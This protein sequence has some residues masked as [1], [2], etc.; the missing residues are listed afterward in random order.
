M[1]RLA[2]IKIEDTKA[3]Y[4]LCARIA[5]PIGEYPLN[6]KRCR[7]QIIEFIRLF[8]K[9]YCCRVLGFCIMGN[10]YHLVVQM[11][12]QRTLSRKEL[13]RRADVLYQDSVLDLWRDDN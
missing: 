11:D 13:R 2:R 1:A 6:N 12:E 7:R 3:Y 10:H 9:V 8:A 5:G 4:H